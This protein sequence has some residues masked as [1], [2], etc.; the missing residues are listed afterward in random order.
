MTTPVLAR[1]PKGTLRS[2]ESSRHT[3]SLWRRTL[4][5][6]AARRGRV[7][8][9]LALTFALGMFGAIEPLLIK[10]YLDQLGGQSVWAILLWILLGLLILGLVREAL[11]A[12]SNWLTWRTRIAFQYELLDA[13]VARLHSL[14]LSYHRAQDVGGVMTRLDRGV[15]GVVGGLSELT[16]NVL[17]A[18]VFVISAAIVMFRLDARATLLVFAFLPIPALVTAWATPEQVR[19]E[20]ALMQHWSSIYGRF[21]EVLSGIVTVKSFVM[22]DQERQRFLRGVSHANEA[23]VRG[24]WR[25]SWV[26]ASKS[27]A[28]VLTRIAIL[29]WGGYWVTRGQSSIG[30]IVAL[31]AFVNALFAPFQGLLGTFQ[32]VQKTSASLEVVF[33]ILDAQDSLGD[34]PDAMDITEVRGDVSF[35]AVWFGFDP[36]QM[37]LSDINLSVEA[38]EIVALVGP[39]GSGKTTLMALLQRLYDPLQG[40]ICVDGKDLRNLKQRALRRHMGVVLQ[41]GLLFNDSVRMNIAYGRP[42]ASLAE[43]IAAAHAAHAHEFIVKMADGYDT[44]VGERGSHLSGGQRQRIAIAR[45]LL[46]DPAILILDEATSA[47]D[48]ESEQ[49]V[50]DALDR[51]VKGRTTFVIAHRLSTVAHADRIVVLK[52][53]RVVESGKHEE[54]MRSQGYYASLVA[55]QLRGFSRAQQALH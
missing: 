27:A 47:L 30:T 45:A 25:D 26:N 20:R 24:V 49:L 51:L 5:M 43:V 3:W 35:E 44:P 14:P 18:I 37:V 22:E 7:A 33:S 13:T 42:E 12:I 15:Q 40:T 28:I 48:A 2:S 29:A 21:N 52:G 9:V 38:G 36:K 41:D 32:S 19:R 10:A 23:V 4:R 50:Q 31:M 11:S 53:G 46:K 55:R 54:L 17:P 8:A 39:S 6:A 34:T 16:F 1:A